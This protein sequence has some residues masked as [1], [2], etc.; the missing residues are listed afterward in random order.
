MAGRGLEQRY[1]KINSK[2][3]TSDINSVKAQQVH[4]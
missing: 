1:K 4:P 3:Y 2:T